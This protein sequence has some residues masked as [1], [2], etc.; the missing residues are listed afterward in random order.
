MSSPY[1]IKEICGDHSNSLVSM[2]PLKYGPN[3]ILISIPTKSNKVIYCYDKTELIQQ[4]NP[5]NMVIEDSPLERRKI[6]YKI[7]TGHD[8]VRSVEENQIESKLVRDWRFEQRNDITKS[9][10][11]LPFGMYVD[12]SFMDCLKR[13]KNSIEIDPNSERKMLF[14]SGGISGLHGEIHNVFKAKAIP[15][16]EML[17][18]IKR[19]V[20]IENCDETSTF[21]ERDEE[22]IQEVIESQEEREE[23]KR[24]LE[25]VIQ[26]QKRNSDILK[27]RRKN[28]A[29]TTNY[30][31]YVERTKYDENG[32][33]FITERFK[34][35]FN[36]T[37][38][39]AAEKFYF[40][41]DEKTPS[42]EFFE[43]STKVLSW[44]DGFGKFHRDNNL[45]ARIA[46]K[47]NIL[48]EEEWFQ[49]GI[50]SRA[51]DLPTFI[52]YFD[53]VIKEEE[54]RYENNVLQYEKTYF[55]NETISSI[56]RLENGD[57]YIEGRSQ[58]GK[59]IYK[60]EGNNISVFD[61]NENLFSSIQK[62][63]ILI[64]KTVYD[65]FVKIVYIYNDDTRKIDFIKDGKVIIEMQFFKDKL[66][67]TSFNRS[68][69]D[70]LYGSPR[71]QKS[72]IKNG[73]GNQSVYVL[74]NFEDDA[75]QEVSFHSAVHI[76]R[77]GQEDVAEF[78]NYNNGDLFRGSNFPAVDL[79][80]GN[81]TY[82][83]Y[84]SENKTVF[85]KCKDG[86]RVEYGH[87]KLDANHEIELK[88]LTI[89]AR[90]NFNEIE[91]RLK[92]FHLDF[93][94]VM[95]RDLMDREFI[96]IEVDFS[97][98]CNI[99]FKLWK[100]PKIREILQNFNNIANITLNF[101]ERIEENYP[102]YSANIYGV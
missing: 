15:R 67:I 95:I 4:L 13:R 55:D 46:F 90:N 17:S 80:D 35:E 18:S 69:N 101:A 68:N 11:R 2:D 93:N 39:E 49:H 72:F 45:P 70:S 73:Q 66:E 88:T 57:Y 62:T 26:Q 51:E 14:K 76:W 50:L 3:L 36:F 47:N 30:E 21:E 58:D 32:D 9:I 10:W 1:N 7:E 28:Q 84:N 23:N 16:C 38:T 31:D 74:H 92:N 24:M 56:V 79:I 60:K 37:H 71:V 22:E 6:E 34:K 85:L 52:S 8:L 83:I 25:L 75:K 99:L 40:Y 64:C 29:L 78:V 65:T 20:A 59:L 48:K 19:V 94:D 86:D 5:E 12:Y 43:N 33:P 102:E 63:D 97:R 91:N 27:N 44:F 96:I 87:G 81:F 42:A 77:N 61:S 54:S 82:N 89:Q 98:I 100:F 53:G 41:S